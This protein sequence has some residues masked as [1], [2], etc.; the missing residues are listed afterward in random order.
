[1]HH[2]K[3]IEVSQIHHYLRKSRC[4]QG[5]MYRLGGD[6]EQSNQT[7]SQNSSDTNVTNTSTNTTSNTS[8]NTTDNNTSTL[9]QDRRLVNERGLGISA[10]DS[11]LFTMNSGNSTTTTNDIT[12]TNNLLTDFGAISGG[13]QLGLGSLQTNRDLAMRTVDA[14]KWMFDSG[15]HLMEAN[16]GFL[17][18]V[19][20]NNAASARNAISEVVAASGNAL[21]QVAS[22][23]AKPLNA[24]DPQ[25]LVIIVALAVV[26]IVVFR[27]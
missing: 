17:Q 8:Y 22:I 20:D 5:V 6:S 23:A 4:A 14:S 21:A 19:G 2:A 24:N 11:T 10:D 13:I 18:H 9:T 1:V 7:T 27:K 16:I 25:R 12:T 15:E 26:A 3:E